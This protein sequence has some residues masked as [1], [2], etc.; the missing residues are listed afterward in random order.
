MQGFRIRP[1]VEGEIPVVASVWRRSR[2]DALPEFEAQQGHSLTDDIGYFRSVIAQ[3]F[4]VWVAES[5]Q[6]I[7]AFLAT[8]DRVVERLYVD[9]QFQGKGI[10]TALLDKAKS[11]HPGGLRL[12]TLQINTRARAFYEARGFRAVA[13]G[14]SPMPENEPDVT[15]EWNGFSAEHAV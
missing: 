13:F 2:F 6:Q 12:F 8:A 3:E 11:N 4:D 14:R 9:P 7:V 15:F 1:L 10:G 5:D